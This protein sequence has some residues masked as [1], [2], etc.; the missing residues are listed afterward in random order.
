MLTQTALS[1]NVRHVFG[2]VDWGDYEMAF[3]A[4]KTDGAEGFLVLFRVLDEERFYWANLG[5]WGNTRHAFE[6]GVEGRRWGAVGRGRNGRI[7]ADRWY[8]IRVRCE[9]PHFQIWLD[10]D[11]VL[12][13]TD[14][15]Q[16]H[17]AGRV[18]LGT[19]N[20]AAQFRNVRVAS[21]DGRTLF[22]G[23]PEV[24]Q[25]AR[26]A[27]FW[28]PFGQGTC[29]LVE[30]N[31]LNSEL[32]LQIT[33]TGPEAGVQQTP[34]CVERN[35]RYTGSLW[36]RGD[37]GGHLIVR[38][39]RDE[40]VLAETTLGPIQADWKEY[41]IEL[42]PN[43]SCDEATLQVALVGQG[44]AYVD[45]VSLMGAD[46]V[47]TGGFR[48]DLLRAIDR[49]DPPIIRW[50]GGC[51]ASSY[52]WKQGIGPQHKRRP[53]PR[54]IWDDLDM[55]TYGT[56]EFIAMCRRVGAEPLIV[57]NIG[58]DNWNA[59]AET[60][61]YLQDVLD[62]IEYCNGPSDSKWG[63]VRAA[64][65]HPEPYGVR[66]WE[67]DN[68]TWHMGAEAYAR[69]VN[70]FAPAMRKADPTIKLAACGSGGFNLEWNRAI[71]EGCAKSIDYLSVHHYE[72]PD[73]FAEGPFRYE[74]FFRQTGELIA[75]STNP[76]MKIY[77]SEWNAQSTDWRTGLYAGGL[78][79]AFERCG[80]VF[81]IGGPA[82]FLR[83]V[84][85][86]AWDNAFINFDHTGWFPAPNYVVMQLWRRYYA[87]Q[88]LVLEPDG[89]PLNVVATKSDDGRR[90]ILK[91]INPT[92]QDG[93]LHVEMTGQTIP[94]EARMQ[95]V[96]PG[97]L[98]ARNTLERPWHVRAEPAAV[99]VDGRRVSFSLP[100][101]SAGVVVIR[102]EHP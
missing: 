44:C 62:W 20:T 95:C 15:D 8:R 12:D 77:C 13:H 97:S 78:L 31:P 50:P 49:L 55:Y 22:E 63:R 1:D 70:R 45:Q 54:A 40:T 73:R 65:G 98:D 101:L 59:D 93:R 91:G 17:P 83:H 56:D 34:F 67:I 41:P 84:S 102:A 25:I 61:D 74:R 42:V 92:E 52:Q 87:P 48:P 51:F 9:G 4:R 89:R 36:A 46:A 72:N 28:E 71:I 39:Y 3:E 43:L 100:K 16:P 33:S 60:H 76:D 81:E 88:L 58:T 53:H 2:N 10:D 27:D 7:E 38:L 85:A 99:H 18:G 90:I 26:V 96:M 68:E 35:V 37:A 11:R 14:A 30:E 5:G 69:A 47:R 23:L 79:N 24:K 29:D 82:L 64:N 32:C 6:K 66:Y 94:V 57:V 21:L 86:R 75:Q 80:E 19:W